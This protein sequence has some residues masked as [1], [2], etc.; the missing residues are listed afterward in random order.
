MQSYVAL[1]GFEPCMLELIHSRSYRPL[2]YHCTT[3]GYH[4]YLNLTLTQA[5]FA[6]AWQRHSPRMNVSQMWKNLIMTHIK[7]NFEVDTT[8][9]NNAASCCSVTAAA[10]RDDNFTRSWP[11]QHW[12]QI[13]LS[14]QRCSYK[15]GYTT[16]G[17][18]LLIYETYSANNQAGK[19]FRHR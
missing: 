16:P 10:V 18:T 6:P 11:L 13:G 5:G 15:T 19:L 14:H 12:T 4:I 9:K 8:R 17:A 1:A 3:A 7:I 2:H